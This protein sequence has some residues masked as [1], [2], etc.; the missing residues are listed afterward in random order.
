MT[1]SLLTVMI[2]D[3]EE[4]VRLNLETFLEDAGF[5]LISVESG[6]EAENVLSKTKVHVGIIDMR[7]PDMDGQTLILAANKLNPDMQYIIHTGSLDYVLPQQLSKIGIKIEQIC[8]KPISDMD[9]LIVK[10]HE[11]AGTPLTPPE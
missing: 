1:N 11:L 7:L 8:H 4:M 9:A 5:D 2:V 10:V 3:D 6:E